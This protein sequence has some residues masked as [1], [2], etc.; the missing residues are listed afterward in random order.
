MRDLLANRLLSQASV[1]TLCFLLCKNTSGPQGQLSFL[2]PVFT[3]L[4]PLF[5][6]H[7][8]QTQMSRRKSKG[9]SYRNFHFSLL[10]LELLFFTKILMLFFINILGVTIKIFFLI[11][12]LAID[13]LF[14]FFVNIFSVSKDVVL[15]LHQQ[16]RCIKIF[17]LLSSSFQPF[18]YVS[19]D[20]VFFFNIL[21]V[22][23]DIVLVFINI[24]GWNR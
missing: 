2:L 10:L 7:N 17:L 22:S 12:V 4:P 1:S 14:L 18:L 9:F 8:F 13:K 15:I 23:R 16:S 19:I 21:G 3:S 6:C 20:M 5:T 24:V 11:L